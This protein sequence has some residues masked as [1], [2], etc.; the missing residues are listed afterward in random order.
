M[1]ESRIP[2]SLEANTIRADPMLLTEAVTAYKK[3]KL[4][5]EKQIVFDNVY[6]VT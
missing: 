1:L 6:F 5:M 3:R 4:E 2:N